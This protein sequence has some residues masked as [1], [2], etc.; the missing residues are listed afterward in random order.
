MNP[1]PGPILLLALPLSAAVLTYLL[2]RWSVLSALLAAATTATLA[3]LCLRLP[4]DGPGF[5]LEQE[6]AF[7]RPV[8]IL[9]QTLQLEPAG[10]LWLAFIFLLA[11]LFF[12]SAWPISQGRSFL[13]FGLVILALYALVILLPAFSLAVLVFGISATLMVFVLQAGQLG[14][15]RGAQRYL[16]VSL[17]AVPLLLAA[18]WMV[19]PSLAGGQN[20]EMARR[21]L[22]PVA[23]GFGL[24]LAAFPFGTWM[25]VVAAEA[26]PIVT[27][28][29][30][31]AGQAMALFLAL[32]F[33]GS[34]PWLLADPATATMLQLA[35]LV[36]CISGGVMAGVQRDFGR[37][38][39][40]AALSDLGVLLLALGGGGSQAVS[41]AL[42][43][44]I[45]R[46]IPIALMA[47]G[48]AIVRHRATTDRF[49]GLPGIARRLPLATA[50]L[51][52]GGLGL[53]GFP[54]TSGFPAHW[55]V[56]RSLASQ[57]WLWTLLLV[58]SSV[59]IIAGLLRGLNAMLGANDRQDVA[60]QPIF[61]SLLLLILAAL[62]IALG[63]YPQLLLDSVQSAAQAFSLF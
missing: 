14:P 6:V 39:G 28:F 23:L 44:V 47:L 4:L 21:A 3:F 19:E 31:T 27:A 22:V 5:I 63:L 30:F 9:G 35:G 38:F 32:S 2:R 37:L 61:A 29:V 1:I 53:A 51:M 20:V 18:A 48:L 55:A 26:P 50:G 11:T 34:N 52:L 59:G 60:R 24:L 40:N 8:V 13:P 49:Q 41:L 12:L 36:M 57:Q 17:L 16:L 43:H 33:L 54:L 46:S 10:Q 7:G 15:I 45:A 56:Y 58:V 42:L 62:T 25:P